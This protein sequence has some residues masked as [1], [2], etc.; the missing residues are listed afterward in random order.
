MRALYAYD[1]GAPR[2]MVVEDVPKPQPAHVFVRGN[3]NNPGI[4][5]PAHFLSCLSPGEPANFQRW[6]R[7]SGSGEGDREQRQSADRARDREPRMDASFRSR[8]CAHAE[9]FRLERRPADA[10]GAT[11]LSGC[12][13]HGIRLVAEETAPGDHAF[14]GLPAEQRRTIPKRGSKIPR[15]NCSGA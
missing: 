10:S 3:P 12:E 14:G 15:I 8:H 4:E 9:R 11:R 6:Q 5:T 7:A 1:G 13:V 2:A